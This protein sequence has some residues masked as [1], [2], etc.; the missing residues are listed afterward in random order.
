MQFQR[1]LTKEV[2]EVLDFERSKRAKYFSVIGRPGERGSIGRRGGVV[3]ID[4]TRNLVR[5]PL[6]SCSGLIFVLR[7]GRV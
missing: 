6:I 1:G 4:Q 7:I 3:G 5:R 2:L